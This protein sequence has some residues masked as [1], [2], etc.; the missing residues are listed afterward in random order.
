[1]PNALILDYGRFWAYLY[2]NYQL[3]TLLVPTA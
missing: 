1:V 3:G 2:P